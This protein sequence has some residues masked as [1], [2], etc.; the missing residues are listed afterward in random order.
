M[1]NRFLFCVT[2]SIVSM[3]LVLTCSSLYGQILHGVPRSVQSR[4]LDMSMPL[5]EPSL[6]TGTTTLNIYMVN[7]NPYKSPC[8]SVLMRYEPLTSFGDLPEQADTVIDKFGQA[9][10]SFQQ[11]GTCKVQ[12]FFTEDYSTS[13]FYLYPGEHAK[14]FIDME[15]L[16]AGNKLRKSAYSDMRM[17]RTG[18]LPNGFENRK[19]MEPDYDFADSSCVWFSGK[20]ANLNMAIHRYVPWGN[21]TGW[22]EKKELLLATHQS[23]KQ[24]YSTDLRKWYEEQRDRVENDER[25]PLC[26]KQLV[27][28][29]LSLLCFEYWQMNL[30]QLLLDERKNDG[31]NEGAVKKPLRLTGEQKEF[32]RSL[33]LNTSLTGYFRECHSLVHLDDVLYDFL[34]QKSPCN[35]LRWLCKNRDADTGRSGHHIYII[36]E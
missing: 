2:R 5:T 8:S 30:Y 16:V 24:S 7:W 29:K 13:C 34:V 35:V 6:E 36:R 33:Q 21:L 26:L 1:M 32:V 15:K 22:D 25:M 18:S 14:V 19:L 23:L 11:T 12:L 17:Y 9:S 27:E 10:F 28:T 31:S 4:T 3:L 20:Y